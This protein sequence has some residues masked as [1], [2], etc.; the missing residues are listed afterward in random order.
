M[1]ISRALAAALMLI[2]AVAARAESPL[3]RQEHR[4]R[5]FQE[6]YALLDPSG[7]ERVVHVQFPLFLSIGLMVEANEVVVTGR[8]A[9]RV[10][11]GDAAFDAAAGQRWTARRVSGTAAR[12][13]FLPVVATFPYDQEE[14]AKTLAKKWQAQ[15]HESA[16]LP[17]G[18]QLVTDATVV[19][20]SRRWYVHVRRFA[21]EALAKQFLQTLIDMGERPWLLER[22][23]EAQRGVVAV[24]D[25]SGAE[26]ARGASVNFES[27]RPLKVFQVHHDVGFPQEG[28][29][30][31][32][33]EGAIQARFDKKGLLAAVN[34]IE[35]DP[36]LKGVVPSE[37]YASDPQQT[38]RAQAVAARGE[39][40]SGLGVKPPIQP[41]DLCSDQN[42]QVYTGLKMQAA[43]TTEG[44]QAT[45]G[46]VLKHGSK[47]VE[48]VYADTCGGHTE[49]V[50]NVWSSP[51]DPTLVGVPDCAEGQSTFP[52]PLTEESLT[53]WLSAN[54]PAYC[55]GEDAQINPKA[56]WTAR[57]TAA[58]L[59]TLI[60]KV[61]KVGAVRELIPVERGVSGRLKILKVVGSA[62]QA[63]IYKELPIRKALGGF[64]S[65]LFVVT[66][67]RDAKGT[68][69]AWNFKGAGWGHGVGL[70]QVGARWAA[71][72]G[73][74][75]KAILAHYFRSS[76]VVKL[77]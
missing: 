69:V 10:T 20:D 6:A 5:T 37:I 45:R 58:E 27:S 66:A 4:A 35:M 12:I 39:T 50:E 33:Y 68:P 76:A 49:N 8:A 34:V 56:R 74:D 13:E 25:P 61:H 32:E 24:V 60:N 75:Y 77:Y 3:A 54:P 73:K 62:S 63:L 52:S 17:A 26:R 48:A 44:V 40:L 23:L 2:G 30:D 38:I 41:Y 18:V 29:E 70:C 67:E 42:C 28:F 16:V 22:L 21:D 36:Y 9:Y 43:S 57:L 7:P 53:A 15:G 59:D 11:C 1:R 55:R 51:P 65:A 47:I 72:A 46:E 64:K 19:N 71:R 14:Q 31:R